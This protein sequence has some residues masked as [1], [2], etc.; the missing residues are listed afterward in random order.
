M[1][2]FVGFF[3]A[4]L[5]VRVEVS[6]PEGGRCI[7]AAQFGPVGQYTYWC[8][9][10][11]GCCVSM[12]QGIL[13]HSGADSQKLCYRTVSVSSFSSIC[14]SAMPA[15]RNCMCLEMASTNRGQTQ[16]LIVLINETAW[17]WP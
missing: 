13:V 2:C 9:A 10:P 15:L 3:G 5:G 4:F 12:W 11:F 8:H 6:A 14:L 17:L 1:C 7:C 16:L